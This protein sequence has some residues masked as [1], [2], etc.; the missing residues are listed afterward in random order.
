ME[1]VWKPVPGFEGV[2]EISSEKRI[3]SISRTGVDKRGRSYPV[4]GRI[5]KGSHPSLTFGEK[6][7]DASVDQIYLEV[8]GEPADYSEVWKPVPGYESLYEVSPNGVIRSLSRLVK[9]KSK[10]GTP[11]NMI[12]HGKQLSPFDSGG[13]LAVFLV[14]N[15]GVIKARAIHRIVAKV[16]VDNPDNKPQVNHIDGD[17]H[18]NSASNLEWVTQSENM[19]HA[20]NTNLWNPN[21]IG[22]SIAVKQGKRIKCVTDGK[23]YLSIASAARAYHMDQNSVLESIELHRPRKGVVFE[24]LLDDSIPLTAFQPI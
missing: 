20:K 18:N 19:Q 15:D 24:F 6:K 10:A 8:F 7:V 11:Y 17:K 9:C 23:L 5:V 12:K 14:D 4:K 22:Y 2:Y 21:G 3:R 1:E 16:F 13:Y